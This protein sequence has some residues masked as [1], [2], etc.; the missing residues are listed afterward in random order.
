MLHTT[1]ANKFLQLATAKVKTLTFTG[2]CYLG[3]SSTAPNQD[4]SNFTEPTDSC[5]ERIQL[6][7]TEA[8][9]YT[10]VF[11]TVANGIVQ[12]TKEF[13]SREWTVEGGSPTFSHFGIFDAPTGGTPIFSD[14]MRDP[15]G[16]PDETTGLY[17]ETT[18][19]IDYG[20]CAVFRAGMLQ[21]TLK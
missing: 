6:S 19:T 14:P 7:I 8:L 16:T 17:P 5:Y 9:N 21:L 15:D 2:K 4:G 3:L 18:M 20:K 1:Y 11:G 10:D 12:N 13:T